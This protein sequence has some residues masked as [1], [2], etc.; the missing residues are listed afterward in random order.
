MMVDTAVTAIPSYG[1]V[2]G[3]TVPTNQRG[4]VAPFGAC[5]DESCTKDVSS[6]QL[7]MRAES[8]TRWQRRGASDL[9]GP[10]LHD[11]GYP[12]ASSAASTRRFVPN[13]HPAP[14]GTNERH[15]EC[16]IDAADGSSTPGANPE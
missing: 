10:P 3:S 11:A 14:L 15:W 2:P 9:N 8:R 16:R 5:P 7:D 4:L 13:D 12:R 6:S 1:P